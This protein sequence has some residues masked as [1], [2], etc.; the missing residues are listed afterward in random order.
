MISRS[1]RLDWFYIPTIIQ[2][3]DQT[4]TL[5]YFISEYTL[6][7]GAIINTSQR[8]DYMLLRRIVIFNITR[9]AIICYVLTSY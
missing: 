1:I 4:I 6:R 5:H 7:L 8:H 2:M 3:S 9:L